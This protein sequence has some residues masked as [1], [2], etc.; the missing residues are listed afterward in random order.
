MDHNP[1]NALDLEQAKSKRKVDK[2]LVTKLVNEIKAS[3]EN[4]DRTPDDDAQIASKLQRLQIRLEVLQTSNEM[5]VSKLQP[6]D[7]EKFYLESEEHMMDTHDFLLDSKQKLN[8]RRNDQAIGINQDET[9]VTTNIAEVVENPVI[10]TVG[11]VIDIDRFS[12][13]TLRVTAYVMKF[14]CLLQKQTQNKSLTADDLNITNFKWIL[15][16]QNNSPDLTTLHSK[17]LTKLSSQL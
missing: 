9:P 2:T 3:F 10:R 5:V 13:L 12:T 7:L 4:E 1:L 8:P 16:A 17:K 6:N 11:N 14:I 15:D